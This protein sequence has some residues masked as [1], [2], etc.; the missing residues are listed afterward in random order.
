MDNVEEVGRATTTTISWLSQLP[1]NLSLVL[2][3]CSVGC[4]K[5]YQRCAIWLVYI[6]G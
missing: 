2:W 5:S 4:P 6:I 3:L 1:T